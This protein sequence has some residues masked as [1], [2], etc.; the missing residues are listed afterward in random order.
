[1]VL[2]STFYDPVIGLDIHLQMVP[3]PPAPPPAGVP[4][5]FPMPFM[6][7]VF[8][9]M[10]LVI[11][12]AMGM[13]LGGGPGVVLV[14]GMPVTNCGTE[15]TNKLTMPHL[16][17]P[18]GFAFVPPPMPDGDATLMFGSLNVSLGGTPG[19]RLGDIAM[20]CSDPVRLPTSVVMAIPKGMPVLNMPP[21]VPDL[22]MLADAAKMKLGMKFLGSM[23]RR[24]GAL[25]RKF[26]GSNFAGK[27]S[28]AL[29][30][31]E[32]PANVSRLREMW[33]RGVRFVT[34][35]PVDVV[36]GNLFTEVVDAELPGPIP[37]VF[38]RVYESARSHRLGRL[39]HGWSHSL[40]EA[41]WLER[42]RAVVR[43]GDG[44]EVEFPLWNLPDRTLR[45]G[46]SIYLAI[47]KLTLRYHG[48]MRAS[49]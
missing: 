30:G 21:P 9:P 47:H 19:V 15:V 46:D 11:G 14:N 28:K 4:T 12:A 42:G 33:H 10:G 18:P 16:F 45:D 5:P 35:H 29:G 27:I 17:I 40:D 25:F 36:T 39:G 7:M 41:F 38:E 26:R 13:A 3:V 1:M 48:G 2:Q 49:V 8:D 23:A 44:R 6:G 43:L 31:C 37:L 32:P 34:G 22:A 20:S 24:A